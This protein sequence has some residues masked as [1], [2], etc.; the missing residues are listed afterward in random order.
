M[1]KP[2][3]TV[4]R[5]RFPTHPEPRVWFLSAGASPIGIAL[6][7]QLLAHGDS[8]VFGTK[9]KEISDPNN[10]RG[11]DFTTFWEEEVLVQEGWKDRAK[12]ISLDGRNM[13]QCQAAVADTTASFKK[14]DILVC[15]SSEAVVGS[16]EELGASPRTT[17]LIRDQFE[18]N[19]FGH[20]NIIKAALP[21]MRAKAR[22]HILLLTGITYEI[23]PFNIRMTI[24]QPTMEIQV[25]TNPIT[26][27][28][29]LAPYTPDVNAA[30]LFREI[31][32]GILDRLDSTASTETSQVPSAGLSSSTPTFP[33]DKIVSVYPQLPELMKDRLLAET[34]NALTAIGGHDNPPARHIVGH[35]AVGLVKEK[36]KTVSEELEEF[37]EVS[38]AV[39][40]DADISNSQ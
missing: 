5:P 36:L 17:A 23:A 18:T 27:A 38:C 8:V 1:N 31:I 3:S 22:G 30:P 10:L 24:V 9:S 16:V 33:P 15:C 29:Q 12:V 13:G 28:P 40:I 2:A 26:A 39:D 19:Y 14:L 7:R 11:I 25:L 6:S 35:E 20:V 4:P 34:I 37:V 21:S 32:G